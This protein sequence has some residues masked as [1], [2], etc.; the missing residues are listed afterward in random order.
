MSGP[1]QWLMVA[2]LLL[3]CVALLSALLPAAQ[4]ITGRASVDGLTIGHVLRVPATV[5]AHYLAP[6]LSLGSRIAISERLQQA[7]LATRCTVSRWVAR[8]MLAVLGLVSAAA[9]MAVLFHLHPLVI[10]IGALGWWLPELWLRHV[11]RQRRIELEQSLPMCAEQIII[12]SHFGQDAD[13]ALTLMQEW[14]PDGWPRQLLNQLQHQLRLHPTPRTLRIRWRH[15]PLPTSWLEL[16]AALEPAEPQ[17]PVIPT[18]AT[19]VRTTVRRWLWLGVAA[20]PAT[21]VGFALSMA[22]LPGS[23]IP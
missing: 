9:A 6:H 13:T 8:Q 1:G 7:G 5:L 2:A 22:L 15:W 17:P 10:G 18:A 11:I 19:P 20:G 4:A 16:I 21:M 14:N 23:A 12:A 3:W